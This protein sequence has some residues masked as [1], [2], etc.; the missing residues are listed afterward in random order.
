[1]RPT[2]P[3]VVTEGLQRSWN[4]LYLRMKDTIGGRL[5]GRPIQYKPSP[6]STLVPFTGDHKVTGGGWDSE[7]R[8]TFEQ[9][10]PYPM[11]VLAIFGTLSVGDHD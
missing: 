11:T 2:I 8:V 4:A 1:M 6:L 7:G 5:N 3:G 9:T 10:E